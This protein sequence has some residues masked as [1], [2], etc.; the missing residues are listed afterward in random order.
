[1]SWFVADA[2]D[3]AFARTKKCLLEPFD[4]WKWMKLAIIVLLIGGSGFNSGGGGNNYSFDESDISSIPPVPAGAA[5][6]FQHIFDWSS[7]NMFGIAFVL[8]ILFLLLV[9]LFSYISSVMEFVFV[10][11]LVKDDVRF[12]KYSR[13]YLG[14]GF[15]LFLLRLLLIILLLVIIAAVT[16]PFIY[17]VMGASATTSPGFTA[18]NAILFIFLLF[19]LIFLLAIAGG[20]VSS[21]I[22]L[23]IPVSLYTGNNI[24]RAFMMVLRNF[25]RDPWQIVLY[26]IGRIVLGLVVAILVGITALVV[27]LLAL[28]IVLVIDG[29]L[30]IV[31]TALW[32]GSAAVWIVLV[33]LIFI[34][35]ILL[36]LAIAFVSMPG[37]VFLRYHL[38][39][40]LQLWYPEIEIPIFDD[41]KG[42]GHE[43]APA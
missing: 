13:R 19:A 32:P 39:T 40:F 25:R 33:A 4:F 12:W 1:M 3:R 28:L 18:S 26:W 14:N 23:S 30:Y 21:F 29:L 34:Q 16:L 15:S 11:S 6:T 35:L 27:I 9:L 2:V 37:Q 10:E 43:E 22:G 20:V 42:P 7:S 24:F 17:I 8:I 5:D 31:L 38:L 41:L 36:I